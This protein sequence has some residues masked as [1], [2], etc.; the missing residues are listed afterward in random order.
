[1]SGD[2]R[3]M[4]RDISAQQDILR[5]IAEDIKLPL[6]RILTHAQL[7]NRQ[8]K[9]LDGKL[10]ESTADI[11]LRLLDSYIASTHIYNGQQQLALEPVSVR[12]V[13]HDTAQYLSRYASQQNCSIDIRVPKSVRLVMANPSTLQAAFI[14]LAYSFLQLL[15]LESDKQPTVI[16]GARLTSGQVQVGVFGDTSMINSATLRKGYALQGRSQQPMTELPYGSGS[17]LL[18]ASRLFEAMQTDLVAVRHRSKRG[19]VALMAPSRQL[20]LDLVS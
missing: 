19:L 14:S 2:N 12:A 6:V 11:A 15:P 13:M 3:L 4:D 18:I 5:N 20:S 1:M 8:G 17:G 7:N 16:L 9:L 10:V